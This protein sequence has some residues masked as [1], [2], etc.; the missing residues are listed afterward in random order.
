[1][2]RSKEF[3]DFCKGYI[4]AALWSSTDNSDES[5]G[6]PLD[7]N[8]SA[9]DI[10]ASSL[11]AMK[12]DCAKF[13]RKNRKALK[14]YTK[15]LQHQAHEGSAYAHAGHDF[16]LTANGH[17]AGFWDRRAWD[18]EDQ[19]AFRKIGDHLSKASRKFASDLEVGDD[20]QIHVMPERK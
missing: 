1:M 8:Y 11:R 17:G 10:A 16:W 18:L 5:G 12:N 7:A 20:G 14:L 15:H 13:F 19:A 3:Q 2:S 6:E 9:D 4:D